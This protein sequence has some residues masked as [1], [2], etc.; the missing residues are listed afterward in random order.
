MRAPSTVL[1]PGGCN[2]PAQIEAMRRRPPDVVLVFGT[3]LLKPP[4]IDAFPGRILNIHLGLSPY[5]RGA[6]TNFWPLVNGEPEYCGATIHFL[7][8]GVDTGPIIAHVRPEMRASDGPHDIGNKT[9]VRRPRRWRT[10]A[11]AG[12]GPVRGVPQAGDGRVYRRADFSADAVTR[13]YA[14]F[15]G[16]MIADYLRDKAARDGP[17]PSCRWRS[18]RDG[19]P[20]RRRRLPGLPHGARPRARDAAARPRGAARPSAYWTE[21]LENIDYLIEASPLI[22]RKLRHHAFHIT[23]IRPY[24]YRDKGDGRREYFEAR[25]PALRALGGDALLVPESPALGGFG[26]TI[27]GQ[28]FNVDT[29]KFYEVLDRH[30]A[31]RR[32][33]GAARDRIGRSSARSAPAGAASPISS[34]PL[35]PR[36]TY[37]L[38]DFPE[39]FLFSATYLGAVFPEAR[40]LFAGTDGSAALE[41]VARRRLRVRAQH[42]W[43]TCVSA[44]PLD[45]TR[46][47][48]VVPGDDRR[49]GARLRRDGRAPRAVRCSTA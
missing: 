3:G 32:A 22:V 39:L 6:G 12:R 42:R 9:I 29:L 8:A 43:R 26:Y 10:R 15:A 44:L 30:G 24:D 41:G 4:L 27:D 49:A 45:L 34:R 35:F 47:H 16:G 46:Q 2:D 19:S 36:A 28:L 18:C 48:G 20:S 25:L 33:A 14:N 1:P 31:G 17:C 40:L 23:G 37:V 21:E 5:Y 38:V 13:L 7:D 11:G